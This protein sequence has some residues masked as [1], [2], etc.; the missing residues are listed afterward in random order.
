MKKEIFELIMFLMQQHQWMDANVGK[1]DA[2][3]NWIVKCGRQ[4]DRQGY[5]YDYKPYYNRGEKYC[6][7]GM[8]HTLWHKPEWQEAYKWLVDNKYLIE[9]PDHKFHFKWIPQDPDSLN[10]LFISNV[11]SVPSDKL[12]FYNDYIKSDKWKEKSQEV[13]K[14]ANFKCDM[15]GNTATEVHHLNYEHLGD[16]PLEDL[17]PLCHECHKKIHTIT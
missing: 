5:E 9:N 7:L 15:C 17:Q 16:E 12:D 3:G 2:N 14:K 11:P 10:Y 8:Y 4:G 6:G 1:K 13:L